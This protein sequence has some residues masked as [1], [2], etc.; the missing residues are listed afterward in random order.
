[1]RVA[2]LDRSD[3]FLQTLQTG[4]IQE[5][6][7]SIFQHLNF[8][9]TTDENLEKHLEAIRTTLNQ[10]FKDLTRQ[11][12]RKV[13]KLSEIQTNVQAVWE[14]FEQIE[15]CEDAS[16]IQIHID[17]FVESFDKSNL[18]T[19][20]NFVRFAVIQSENESFGSKPLLESLK[21]TSRCQTDKLTEYKDTYLKL[22]KICSL[23]KA[24]YLQYTRKDVSESSTSAKM[25]FEDTR[26][27]EIETAFSLLIEE[28]KTKEQI[29]LYLKKNYQVQKIH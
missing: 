26:Y 23:L 9:G 3:Q 22:Y 19:G 7:K 25:N 27:M 4:I 21:D 6:I 13:M 20:I 10:G 5:G 24:A 18:L 1:M 17:T 29:A 14:D 2:A 15:K 28:C 16:E 8:R 11:E 12:D